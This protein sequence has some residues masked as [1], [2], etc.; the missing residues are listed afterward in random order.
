M[1]FHFS[2]LKFGHSFAR[3]LNIL[4][5]Q[6]MWYLN[7]S[8]FGH[9]T[10]LSFPSHLYSHPFD[11][12][13]KV[14]PLS[15][16]IWKCSLIN[17]GLFV[18]SLSS[19]TKRFCCWITHCFF[20]PKLWSTFSADFGINFRGK[21]W[22]ICLSRSNIVYSSFFFRCLRFLVVDVDWNYFS[23]T[24]WIIVRSISDNNIIK[25]WR[26]HVTFV[27]NFIIY[28]VIVPFCVK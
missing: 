2:A 22:K 26:K 9:V 13:F 8:Q 19:G 16:R 4:F 11:R 21:F 20:L 3:A 17:L 25:G 15:P 18:K 23:S 14:W 5:K 28:P 10:H 6:P 12:F 27:L 7:R 1:H 24:W